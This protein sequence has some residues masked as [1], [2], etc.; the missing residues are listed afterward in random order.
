M[1]RGALPRSRLTQLNMIDLGGGAEDLPHGA[2]EP[3]HHLSLH[4]LNSKCTFLLVDHIP[5]LFRLTNHHRVIFF[6]LIRWNGETHAP[7][8]SEKM[9]SPRTAN[10]LHLIRIGKP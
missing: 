1:G 3:H 10:Y 9:S 7:F 2:G 4:S 8:I 6:L 5:G